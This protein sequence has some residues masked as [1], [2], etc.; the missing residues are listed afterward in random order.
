MSQTVI[1]FLDDKEIFAFGDLHGDILALRLLLELTDLIDAPDAG[2]EGLYEKTFYESEL[3]LNK[4]LFKPSTKTVY[5]IISRLS[6]ATLKL[7]PKWKEN[8]INKVIIVTG[9]M[10]D[11]LRS[12][13]TK[14]EGTCH[15]GTVKQ[16]ELK[17]VLCLKILDYQAIKAGNGCRVITLLG[18]HE[19][20]NFSENK[21]QSEYFCKD[22]EYYYDGTKY[23]TREAFFSLYDRIFNF[24][25]G[26]KKIIFR[27]N[28]N[29]FMH[30]GMTSMI[31]KI[32]KKI[33]MKTDNTFE[34]KFM[35]KL[36]DQLYDVFIPKSGIN[37]NNF[38]ILINLYYTFHLLEYDEKFVGKNNILWNKDFGELNNTESDSQCTEFNQMINQFVN[39]QTF[40]L[41]IGHCTQTFASYDDL[42]EN[43]INKINFFK[44]RF[45]DAEFNDKL[46][47]AFIDFLLDYF[48]NIL[49]INI[50]EE[51]LNK[52][53][54]IYFNKWYTYFK[55][56]S[57]PP[58]IPNKQ[59][60]SY[61]HSNTERTK[62]K[63]VISGTTILR[64]ILDSYD[65][66]LDDHTYNP[67]LNDPT[68]KSIFSN[69][70][71]NFPSFIGINTTKCGENDRIFRL[72]VGMSKAF[73]D[74]YFYKEF[75]ELYEN[76][77]SIED[78]NENTL[79]RII[80]PTPHSH[81]I[82][83]LF[84][85]LIK[86]I[87]SRAP[88]LLHITTSQVTE[89]FRASLTNTLK[90][91]CRNNSKIIPPSGHV[92]YVPFYAIIAYIDC[93]TI[94]KPYNN[95]LTAITSR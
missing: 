82:K 38:I 83:K 5:D 60:L 81:Y 55:Y 17:I 16:E 11:N 66:L 93:T 72:D 22:D 49:K 52:E 64:N 79:E 84:F 85:L 18:N 69:P 19:D 80:N 87:L 59:I 29:I 7:F 33:F 48:Q 25:D 67:K 68:N 23:I 40:N 86:Y 56:F 77:K 9:D 35:D 54:D 61:F 1:N 39:G 26:H 89:V 44:K 14:Q 58:T 90:Y 36:G 92:L 15:I 62:D 3:H 32:F 2:W 37:I 45:V 6:D 57:D 10:I 47:L 94:Q 88:Q 31:L 27:V 91:M 8:M 20:M 65:S 13:Y 53:N 70:T 43:F 51:K 76:S 75:A 71:T 34:E 24:E 50:T 46:K 4:L 73:D 78:I 74:E 28:N 41:I 63:H 42:N 12:G 30:G 21:I 95:Y